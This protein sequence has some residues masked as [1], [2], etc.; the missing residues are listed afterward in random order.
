MK[1][2]KPKVQATPTQSPNDQTKENN[3]QHNTESDK[4]KGINTKAIQVYELLENRREI[5]E[6]NFIY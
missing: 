1:T 6:V 5:A 3:L 2:R 4:N